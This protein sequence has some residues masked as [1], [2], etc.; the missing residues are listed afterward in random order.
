M[1]EPAAPLQRALLP[2]EIFWR[3]HQIWLQSCG[4]MLR[5]RYHPDWIPSW[6]GSGKLYIYFED[7]IFLRTVNLKYS[8]LI[9]ATRTADGTQVTIKKIQKSVPEFAI[10]TE[11]GLYFSRP[12]QSTNPQNHCIPTYEVL[13]VPD[14]DQYELIIMPN[15]RQYDSPRFDT[16]GE[17]VEYFRQ[18]FEGVQ[19][20]HKHHVAHRDCQSRNIMMDASRLYP[21]GFHPEDTSKN[22]NWKGKAKHSTRTKCNPKYY[23]IDFGLSRMYDPA[24]GPPLE[25][26]IRGGDKSAPEFQG[27]GYYTLSD[28][29]RTDIYYL[30]NMIRQEFIEGW[31]FTSGKVGFEFMKPLVADMVA[32]DPTKRPTIDE[33]V[34]RFDE[35]R[36]AL[37]TWKLRS[38]VRQ[39]NEIAIAAFFVREIPH[40]SRRLR[41]ILSGISPVPV[42]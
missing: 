3:D 5:P 9:D 15:L 32:D 20:M 23:L 29:F 4:Y 2:D 14:D 35:I 27:E 30:G 34:T 41:Y 21:N 13:Q 28:P 36:R 8:H 26:P 16:F 33:V 19:F 6:K 7:S 18:V 40:W 12:P 10:E 25:D 42:P 38:R 22:R 24:N 11:I 39:R 1:A 31:E 37:S 17:V